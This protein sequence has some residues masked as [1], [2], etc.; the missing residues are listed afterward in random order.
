V[1][2]QVTEEDFWREFLMK[3]NKYSTEVFGGN[4][5]LFIPFS[6]DEMEYDEIYVNDNLK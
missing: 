6:T 5:P 3:N 4:N 1:P 2:T